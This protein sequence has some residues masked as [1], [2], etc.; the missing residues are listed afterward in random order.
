MTLTPASRM[1]VQ[2]AAQVCFCV[3]FINSTKYFGLLRATLIFSVLNSYSP[4]NIH[5]TDRTQM[6]YMVPAKMSL[7]SDFMNA[8]AHL[9]QYPEADKI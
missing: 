9:Y 7:I 4:R 8:V 5:N 3:L 6:Q 2:F 1:S